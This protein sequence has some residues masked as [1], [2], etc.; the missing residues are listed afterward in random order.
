MKYGSST[1]W[2]LGLT[3]YSNQHFNN[4]EKNRSNAES[5]IFLL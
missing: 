3:F 5:G 4:K 2:F 1:E